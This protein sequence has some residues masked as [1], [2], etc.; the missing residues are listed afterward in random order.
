MAENTPGYD[1]DLSFITEIADGSDEFIVESIDMFLN[2]TPDLLE[3]IKRGISEHNWPIVASAS[4]KLKPNLG[5]FG[6]KISQG[7]FQ[8]IET[9][10]KTGAPEPETLSAKYK[11]IQLLLKGTLS[12]LAKIREEKAAGL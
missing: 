1:L 6:M 5:F 2:Q 4:H 7:I 8:E 9:M 3:T 12:E 10:A 11:D